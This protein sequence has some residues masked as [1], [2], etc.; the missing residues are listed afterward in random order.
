MSDT[1]IPT[2]RSITLPPPLAQRKRVARWAVILS[3]LSDKE[4][5]VC[6]LVS[7][8]FRYAVYLSASSILLRDYNGRRLQQDV[9]RAYPQAMTDMWPY[10]RLREAEVAERRRMY[11]ASFLP[12]FFRRCGMT[13]PIAAHLWASPDDPRQ[14]AIALSFALTRVWFELSLG[15][16][17]GSKS[18]P[19]SWLRGTIIDVQ[20][21]VR[22]DVWSVSIQ[23]SRTAAQAGARET[24]HVLESTCE[25]VGRSEREGR[26][27]GK[28]EDPSS[29]EIRAD[30]SAYIANCSEPSSDAASLLSRVKWPCREEFMQGISKIW[31]KRIA[32][33]GNLGQAK[34]AVAERYVL[35]SVVGNR[36]SPG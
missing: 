11:E 23:H 28:L 27:G 34:L 1:P 14:I 21:V 16:S 31:L 19:R 29:V 20:E 33:E 30:W 24:L 26:D 35:A 4:R 7:R 2:L 32:G 25:V 18:D 12:R 8:T 22:G 15:S 17:D 36:S 5:A 10:L 6:I 13:N 3:G 9:L